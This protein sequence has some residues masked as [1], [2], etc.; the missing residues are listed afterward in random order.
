MLV[1]YLEYKESLKPTVFIEIF[2]VTY[3]I[4]HLL[5]VKVLECVIIFTIT[6]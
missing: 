4:K 3:G 6:E 5:L 2:Q 1:T